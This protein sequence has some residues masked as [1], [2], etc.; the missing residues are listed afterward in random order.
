MDQK[1]VTVPTKTGE[2]ACPTFFTVDLLTSTKLD[3]LGVG[4]SNS[5]TAVF[6]KDE[7]MM[8]GM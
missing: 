8:F 4:Q 3:R 7:K 2:V 6:L 1:W 5:K